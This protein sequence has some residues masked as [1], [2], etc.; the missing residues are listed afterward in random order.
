MYYEKDTKVGSQNIGYQICFCNQTDYG[1]GLLN[2]LS[3]M[4]LWLSV[5]GHFPENALREWLEILHA[6]VSWPPSEPLL[7]A[8]NL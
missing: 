1:R 3:F 2:F 8:I 5:S 4:P 7:L 6:D